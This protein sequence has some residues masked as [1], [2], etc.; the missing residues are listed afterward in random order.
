MRH[1]LPAAAGLL[2]LCSLPGCVAVPIL[3][4]GAALGHAVLEE[5]STLDQL[6]DTD[7]ALGI[8]NRLGNHSGQLY[9]DV[10]VDVVE[11]AVVLTGTV[12]RPEDKIAAA[13]AVWATP[14]V[15]A[16]DDALEVA[17]DSGTGAY[18]RDLA[19]SN[20]VRYELVAEPSVSAVNY[21]VTTV[22]GA[23]HLTGLAR[24]PA[25]L[26]RA[27]EIARSVAG[28]R[29]VVSHVLTIDDPR[30]RARIARGD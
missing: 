5:R 22:D 29:R 26:D 17:E 18:L 28:V 12:P 3:G 13:G 9:R 7:I 10:T 8:A 15:V 23:V 1:T 2:V 11:G 19:I 16:L 6:E 30:R 4:G 24:S 25:E 21:T 14:G 27:I 20:R